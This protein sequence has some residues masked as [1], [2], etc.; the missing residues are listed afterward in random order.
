MNDMTN[1]IVKDYENMSN[2]FVKISNVPE[3]PGS[4]LM[5][6]EKDDAENL[7]NYRSM[8]GGIMYLTSKI[9]PECANA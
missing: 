5:K 4:Y 9:S 1:S 3:V 7:E 2:K 8:V 6:N